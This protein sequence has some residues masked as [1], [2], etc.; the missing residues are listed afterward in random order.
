MASSVSQMADQISGTTEWDNWMF[1]WTAHEDPGVHRRRLYTVLDILRHLRTNAIGMPNVRSYDIEYSG[2]L[3]ERLGSDASETLD[4]WVKAPARDLPSLEE[5]EAWGAKVDE[6]C[7]GAASHSTATRSATALARRVAFECDKKS[8]KAHATKRKRLRE[9]KAARNVRGRVVGARSPGGILGGRMVRPPRR[10]TTANV[11]KSPDAA[12]NG[13]EARVG[14]ASSASVL[15]NDNL[16]PVFLIFCSFLM[17]FLLPDW[18]KDHWGS[19]DPSSYITV[20]F[21]DVKG[22]GKVCFEAVIRRDNVMSLIFDD[23]CTVR[24]DMTTRKIVSVKDIIFRAFVAFEMSILFCKINNDVSQITFDASGVLPAVDLPNNWC[25]E[26]GGSTRQ[27]VL[28]GDPGRAESA[29]SK[30]FPLV[31]DDPPFLSEGYVVRGINGEIILLA[32]SADWAHTRH[33]IIDEVKKRARQ[34]TSKCTLLYDLREL[35]GYVNVC[36]LPPTEGKLAGLT[37]VFGPRDT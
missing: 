28:S 22:E 1:K 17:K 25:V 31:F 14:A 37:A 3:L 11:T 23:D 12:S 20:R 13:G 29:F 30:P 5:A 6:L 26:A 10:S 27:F 32:D 2:S 4:G 33:D 21:F 9:D 7:R 24:F 36:H 18:I 15:T 34:W 16:N 35:K 19:A 8:A